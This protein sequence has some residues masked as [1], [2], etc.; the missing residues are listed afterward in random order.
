MTLPGS[1]AEGGWRAAWTT[2]LDELEL[3]ATRAETLMADHT[4]DP[5][6]ALAEATSPW[7]PPDVGPLPSDL[8]E[9]AAAVLE[10]HLAVA[11]E[12]TRA[13]VSARRHSALADRLDGGTAPS[14][15][16]YV[17]RAC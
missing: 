3:D 2:A 15:A 6:A 8:R 1:S 9:R 5:A 17:D 11:A 10:R 12:L 16:F 4:L 7:S 13:V 14:R